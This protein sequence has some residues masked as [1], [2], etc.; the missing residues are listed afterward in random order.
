MAMTVDFLVKPAMLLADKDIISGNAGA[1]AMMSQK[2]ARRA[3][4]S[5]FGKSLIMRIPPMAMR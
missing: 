2:P 3:S 1:T 5:S 4:F